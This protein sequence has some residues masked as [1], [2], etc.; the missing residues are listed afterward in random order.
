MHLKLKKEHPLLFRDAEEKDK[1]L[2]V[3]FLKSMAEEEHYSN[4]NDE[5]IETS[6]NVVLRNQRYGRIFMCDDLN[7]NRAIGCAQFIRKNKK[8]I[9]G[10]NLFVE[11][12]SRRKG[13]CELIFREGEEIYRKDGV[14]RSKGY[15]K[16]KNKVAQ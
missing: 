14:I 3:K 5:L 7:E 10:S 2:I 4:I 1:P 11:K 8:E 6:V 16:I 9:T 12:K 15:V 13:A